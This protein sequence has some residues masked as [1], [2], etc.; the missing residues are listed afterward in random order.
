[1][2]WRT[3]KLRRAKNKGV[4]Y[5][6]LLAADGVR[7]RQ[8]LHPAQRSLTAA[9]ILLG[10]RQFSRGTSAPDQ[11]CNRQIR[12]GTSDMNV[13][14]REI[15]RGAAG[16]V[17]TGPTKG[18][19]LRSCTAGDDRRGP[20]SDGTA[21]SRSG[22]AQGSRCAPRSPGAERILAGVRRSTA[23]GAGHSAVYPSR[24]TSTARPGAGR[25]GVYRPLAPRGRARAVRARPT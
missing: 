17:G 7:V 21:G 19:Q 14:F 6:R 23:G 22:A 24:S 25:G 9:D 18:V 3:P 13:A 8:V 2:R 1:M 10:C 4:D 11:R 15:V 20:R 5:V 12:H 16:E